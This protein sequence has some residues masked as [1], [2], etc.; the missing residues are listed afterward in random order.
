M[1]QKN[2]PK[3]GQQGTF[4]RL[5]GIKKC[6][7]SCRVA[8]QAK[9]RYTYAKPTCAWVS[10][11]QK[12]TKNQSLEH[13]FFKTN[14]KSQQKKPKDPHKADVFIILSFIGAPPFWIHWALWGLDNPK[15]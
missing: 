12:Q 9:L 7:G 6:L 3:W 8:N 11:I 13:P 1:S 2:I 14:Q 5:F 4:W 15:A 10:E